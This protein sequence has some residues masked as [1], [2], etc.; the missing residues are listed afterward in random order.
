[1]L[2]MSRTSSVMERLF[3]RILVAALIGH[4]VHAFRTHLV[5]SSSRALTN[6]NLLQLDRR[7]Q[8]DKQLCKLW[9]TTSRKDDNDV[10]AGGENKQQQPKGL[11]A[12]WAK[13]GPLYFIVW[14]SIYVPFLITFYY[15]LDNDIMNTSKYGID[16]PSAL[17]SLIDT[18][19]RMTKNYD[20]LSHLRESR[21][22]ANFA[23]AYLCA[24]LVPTTVFAL[25]AVG[26]ITTRNGTQTDDDL[27]KSQ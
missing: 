10:A 19:E 16:P 27:N 26:Y 7:R 25:G 2:L 9:V 3:V 24:D 1:M 12:L 14:F 6:I 17:N 13:Y 15:L 20:L 22:A 18:F 23:A 8:S 4:Q 11:A 5:S 21:H